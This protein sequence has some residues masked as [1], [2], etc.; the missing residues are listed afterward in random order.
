MLPEAYKN[1]TYYGKGPFEAYADRQHAA[2]LGVFKQTVE[3]QYFPYIRPQETGNKLDVRWATITKA[4]GSGNGTYDVMNQ[5]TF[6]NLTLSDYDLIIISATTEAHIAD[7][8]VN[9]LGSKAKATSSLMAD[10]SRP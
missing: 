1:I 10:F 4:D 5:S 8:L 3:E 9:A 6:V 2:K 7:D